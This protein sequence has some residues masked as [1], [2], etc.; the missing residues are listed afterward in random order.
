ML[1]LAAEK[2]NTKNNLDFKHLIMCVCVLCCVCAIRSATTYRIFWWSENK[3]QHI[4]QIRFDFTWSS[5][6]GAN[7]KI[8]DFFSQSTPIQGGSPIDGVGHTSRTWG[9][10]WTNEMRNGTKDKTNK[11]YVSVFVCCMHNQHIDHKII[12]SKMIA[13]PFGT[14][15][16]NKIS[17]V[18]I[19]GAAT[20]TAG[21][22]ELCHVSS[23]VKVLVV[24]SV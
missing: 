17:V 7:C 22:S 13:A 18:F 15:T 9:T 20:T 19:L 23:S 6:C 10:I 11:N 4:Y 21:F 24:V 5:E 1:F 16:K 2:K 8:F 3:E 14:T 12:L